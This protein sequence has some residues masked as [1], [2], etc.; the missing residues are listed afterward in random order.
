MASLKF[1]F[2]VALALL[3]VVSG[4][5]FYLYRKRE[6]ERAEMERVSALYQ[7]REDALLKKRMR[8]QEAVTKIVPAAGARA[9]AP[10]PETPAPAGR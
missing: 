7:A 9:A 8:E 10:V 6:T 1:L 3:L 2:V 4:T 5:T